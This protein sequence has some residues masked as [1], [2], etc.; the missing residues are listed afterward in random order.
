MAAA[1]LKV[2]ASLPEARREGAGR[3]AARFH[4]DPAGWYQHP[5]RAEA[6]AD[7]AAAVWSDRRIRI[8]YESWKARVERVLDPLGLALK[9]GVW[10]LVARAEGAPRTYRVS[11]ILSLERTDQR[12]A[13]PKG[14]D[15]ARYWTAWAKDFE[16]RL[17]TGKATLCLS[18]EGMRRLRLL[19]AAVARMA[20]VTAST[21]GEDGWVTAEIP[22][23]SIIHAMGDV[24]KLGAEA[25]VIAPPELRRRMAEAAARL[26]AIYAKAPAP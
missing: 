14:F 16:D 22:T 7:L 1:Q 17:Y 2:L 18:P 23:E 25:E 11:N 10:Y 26:A 12:F 6:L 19:P 20:A 4:L 15:L 5:E 24:L 13:R 8:R 3:I 21:P 9:A